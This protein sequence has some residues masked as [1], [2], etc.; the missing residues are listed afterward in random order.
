MLPQ[1]NLACKGVNLLT[2]GR[3]Q[4]D[5]KNVIFNLALFIG[6]FKSTY[7]NVLRWMPEDLTD[8]K[9]TLVQVMVGCR[10]ATSHYLNQCCW[11]SS[12]SSYGITGPQ[13]VK[14][15]L[16]N[17]VL[18]CLPLGHITQCD[19]LSS[20]ASTW[21]NVSEIALNMHWIW[22]IKNYWNFLDFL[23]FI[24]RWKSQLV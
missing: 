19:N 4:C 16:I 22:V 17:W 15:W 21:K 11:P 6:I 23:I 13:W 24:M 14:D 10:Q 5:F 18:H 1:K 7:D 9:S 12:L 2:P 8:D 3:T 20:L